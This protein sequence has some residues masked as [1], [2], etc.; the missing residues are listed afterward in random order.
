MA[1][2]R[3]APTAREWIGAGVYPWP[4]VRDIEEGGALVGCYSLVDVQLLTTKY[5]KPYLRL[6]LCDRHGTIDARIWDD[7]ESLGGRLRAG[8]F[9]GVRGRVEVFRDQHQLRVEKI[10]PLAVADDELELFMPRSSRDPAAMDRELRA[11]VAS[12][13]EPALRALLERLLGPETESGRAFRFAPAAKLNHH[14]YVGGLIEHTLSVVG[15]CA[16]LA[17]HYGPRIDHDLLLAGALL[18]DIG[19]TREIQARPG[20]PYTDEGKLL[21]HI[22]IG[23]EMVRAASAGID[24]L[25][26]ERLDLLLHLVASHQGRYEWQSP[27]EPLTLEALLL[28]YADDIDAKMRTAFDLVDRVDAGWTGY[29][30]GLRRQLFRHAALGEDPP[31]EAARVEGGAD[32]PE[33]PEASDVPD[34]PDR[35]GPPPVDRD[36]IDLFRG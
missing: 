33:V 14:A 27:R 19:K 8:A 22:L 31:G 24:E 28:H 26:P 5:D 36:T 32:A 21:G 25:P 9:V 13:G 20:F 12:V 35:E 23:L 30:R 11:H 7:A 6:Q 29:D 4:A 16:R 17:A 1:E 10:R 34:V 2:A 18:H 3:R 15:L